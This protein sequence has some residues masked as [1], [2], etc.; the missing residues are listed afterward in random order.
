LK[1]KKILTGRPFIISALSVLCVVSFAVSLYLSND[2]GMDFVPD[3]APTG[4]LADNE[5]PISSWEE[6]KSDVPSVD[7]GNPIASGGEASPRADEGQYPKEVKNEDDN[8]VVDF[9]DPEP[10]KP[11]PPEKPVTNADSK[12]PDKP[13]EYKPE[14]IKPQASTSPGPA[15]GSKNEKG[16]IYDQAFGWIKPGKAVAEPIHNDGDPNKQIGS[17]D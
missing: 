1:L 2:K 13:P 6:N 3:P 17:M 9:T 11:K 8:V 14:E 5:Q 10:E 7:P 12:N 4:Q 16:E 15:P